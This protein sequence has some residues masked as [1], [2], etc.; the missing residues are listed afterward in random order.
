MN[1]E[2]WAY[3]ETICDSRK[4]VL[5]NPPTFA[6]IVNSILEEATILCGHEQPCDDRTGFSRF[7]YCIQ[8]SRP[9][10]DL[11]FNSKNGYRGQYFLSADAGIEMNGHFIQSLTAALLSS[12]KVTAVPNHRISESL[13]AE[14]AKAW[15][16]ECEK[17]LCDKCRGEWSPPQDDRAEI[18]NGCWENYRHSYYGRKA[19]YLTKIRIFGAFLNERGEE[20]DPKP[21]RAQELY[22][23]GWT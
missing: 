8:V 14:S 6:K 15:L 17:H 4:V 1:I 16:A 5:K 23:S 9:L 22:E 13:S 18:L 2:T 12:S 3:S 7:I 21:N 10:F 19:P 11:L 20:Y